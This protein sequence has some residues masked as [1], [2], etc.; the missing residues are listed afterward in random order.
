MVSPWCPFSNPFLHFLKFE[1]KQGLVNKS[2][3]TLYTGLF[4]NFKQCNY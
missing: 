2:F 3:L 4:I 1:H